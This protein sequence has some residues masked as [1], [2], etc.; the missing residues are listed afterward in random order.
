MKIK[1][2][3]DFMNSVYSLKLKIINPDV[4]KHYLKFKKSQFWDID[5]LEKYQFKMMKKV[6]TCAYEQHD[7]YRELYD[8][9]NI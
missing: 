7:F 2:F 1:S 9:K 4:Y 6:I 5:E 3:D 8:S